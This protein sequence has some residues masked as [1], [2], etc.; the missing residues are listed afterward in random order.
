M[1]LDMYL[2]KKI[3]IG[4]NYDFNEVEGTVSLTRKGKPVNVDLKK[5]TYIQEAAG[6]WRKANQIHGWFVA[7]VQDGVDDCKQ[8]YVGTSKLEELLAECKK[9]KEAIAAGQLEVA[10]DT[11][12]TQAGFFFGSTAYDE[13]Y[14]EDINNTIAICEEA[15][16]DKEADYYYQSSW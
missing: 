4:A 16:K 14:I 3:Y 15:L 2:S 6:Y 12:P 10:A 8:Y 7:N 5:V 13:W 11:L 1:G 9:V